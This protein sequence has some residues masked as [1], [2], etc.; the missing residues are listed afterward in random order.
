MSIARSA[1]VLTWLLAAGVPIALAVESP[2]RLVRST[3]GTKGSVQGTRYVIEDPRTTFY[4]G[5]DRQVVVYF[6]WDGAARPHGCKIT[7][8]DPSG[9]AVL[10]SPYTAQTRTARFGVS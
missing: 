9:A 4:A 2:V 5:T 1:L 6:E 3:S 7:W 8:K 10:I